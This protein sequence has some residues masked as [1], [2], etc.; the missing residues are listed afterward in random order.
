[1]IATASDAML[2][3]VTEVRVSWAAA[4]GKNLRGGRGRVRRIALLTED[5][6]RVNVLTVS[7]LPAETLITRLMARWR[8]QENALKHQVERWGI[9]HLD[10]PRVE[11]YPPDAVIPKPAS[12]PAD[13]A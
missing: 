10:G 3:G 2:A 6:R 8:A 1:M 13:H 5:R 11:V 4:P 12:R 9:N 7:K